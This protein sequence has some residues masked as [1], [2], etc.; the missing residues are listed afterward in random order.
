MTGKKQ[1]QRLARQFYQLSLVDDRL[2]AERVAGV[3]EYIEKNPP[4]YPVAVLKAYRRLVAEEVARSQAVVEHAGPVAEATLAAIG[5]ALAQRYQRPVSTTA[6]P[7]PALL[8]GLRI[9]IGDDLYEA[10]I[11][12]QLAELS[13]AA[14]TI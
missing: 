11:A 1:I 4:A 7:N 12:R 9:R 14:N 6:R 10:S 2:D 8:A 13:S 3:L 5:A